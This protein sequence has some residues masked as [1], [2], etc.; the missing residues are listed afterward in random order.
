MNSFPIIFS[1][2]FGIAYSCEKVEVAVGSINVDKVSI[3]SVLENFNNLFAF[4]F[5]H[6][7]VVYVYAN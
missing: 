5:T 3:Q 7:P 6:K 4:A 2:G 1:L